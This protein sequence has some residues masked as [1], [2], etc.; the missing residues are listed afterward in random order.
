MA[1]VVTLKCFSFLS[2]PITISIVFDNV[3]YFFL[4]IAFSYMRIYIDWIITNPHIL[5]AD[6]L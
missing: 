2:M 4:S 5:Y 3:T 6:L 1:H